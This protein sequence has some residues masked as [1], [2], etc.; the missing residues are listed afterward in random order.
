V[1]GSDRS[2]LC[3]RVPESFGPAPET[4][5]PRGGAQDG[6][7]AF[8]R[9]PGGVGGGRFVSKMKSRSLNASSTRRASEAVSIFRCGGYRRIEGGQFTTSWP[10]SAAQV[11]GSSLGR[12]SFFRSGLP[13]LV[14][15]HSLAMKG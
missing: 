11:F 5:Y 10:S 7:R 9:P 6:S 8:L 15:A 12:R 3:E 1:V 4:T 14:R 13:R 2:F